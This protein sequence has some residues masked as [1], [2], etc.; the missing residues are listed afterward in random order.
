VASQPVAPVP[1]VTLTRSEAAAA[2]GMSL[3]SFE[4]HVQP[5]LRLVRRGALRLVPVRELE[6]WAAENA[7]RVLP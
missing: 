1:R 3:D 6:V 5:Q 7:E 4:R 2:M